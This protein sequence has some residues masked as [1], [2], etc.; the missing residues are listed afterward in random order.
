MRNPAPLAGIL[1]LLVVAP[2][3]AVPVRP[4]SKDRPKKDPVAEE[5]KLLQGTWEVVGM[6]YNGRVYPVQTVQSLS[7]RLTISGNQYT[8]SRNGQ[9]N[10]GIVARPAA[11][12]F[13]IDPTKK[14]KEI[15]LQNSAAG[16][17]RPILA[18]YSLEGDTLKTCEG[19]VGMDRPTEFKTSQGSRTFLYTWKRMK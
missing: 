8:K 5:T 4:P 7:Y 18:I 17:K 9:R 19:R 3:S 6:E 13:K 10:G 12:T 11:Y 2:L 15:D 1:A 16:V 14:I